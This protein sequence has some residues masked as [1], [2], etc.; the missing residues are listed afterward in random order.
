MPDTERGWHWATDVTWPA[1]AAGLGP[2]NHLMKSL[3]LLPLTGE[4]AVWINAGIQA[5]RLNATITNQAIAFST[6]RLNPLKLD[7][8]LMINGGTLRFDRENCVS[9]LTM[10]GR[11]VV[12]GGEFRADLPS[13]AISSFAHS[14]SATNTQRFQSRD[15]TWKQRSHCWQY[16]D[17]DGSK[18]SPPS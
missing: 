7:D 17:R 2:L 12:G 9:S 4:L 8:A 1:D 10:V 3:C 6:A 18:A 14:D 11:S 5:P 15:V 13:L 16:T